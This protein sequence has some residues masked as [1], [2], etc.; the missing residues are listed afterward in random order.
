[1]S[2]GTAS[3]TSV[4]SGGSAVAQYS[5][6]LIGATIND[7]GYE[8]INGGTAS[9]T[10]IGIGGSI[11]LTN[12]GYS[13]TG[14]TISFNSTTDLLTVTSGTSIYTQTLAG[15]YTGDSFTSA[16]AGVGGTT[17]LAITLTGPPCYCAGTLILTDNGERPVEDLRAGDSV[18]TLSGAIRPIRWVGQ[19][20]LAISRHLSPEQVQ[21]VLIRTD[22]IA[23][24]KPHRDLRV[25]PDHAVLF[26]RGLIP[27]RLLINGASIQQE[28]QCQSVTYYHLE[29]DTHDILL[30]EGLPAESYLDTGNRSLFENGGVPMILHP[31]C[32]DGQQRR[33]SASCRPFVDRPADVEPV[34]R[35]LAM[36][37]IGLGLDLPAEPDT[38]TDP[39]LHVVLDGQA[40]NPISIA[41]GRYT[42]LLPLS[43]GP[44]RLV[45][46]VVRPSD[47]RPWIEDQRRLGVRLSAMTLRIGEKV[48][49][50]SLE[51]PALTNGWWNAEH[52]DGAIRRW[53]D[54]NAVLPRS[55]PAPGVLEITLADTLA[56]PLDRDAAADR[57]RC[58]A[59]A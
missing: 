40:I 57:T 31:N 9:F 19:R 37:A 14:E 43:D 46:R 59:A 15:N 16:N 17:E 56:Y 13:S 47:L 50:I 45:S 53:T 36:R 41:G 25:S 34:W 24:G 2:G 32:N 4:E 38:T 11:L 28:E 33:E 20:H 39:D 52:D 55:V 49:T 44:V 42:F 51:D 21:P 5:G 10:S 35:Q 8:I 22:A 26:D 18:V 1:M 12:F 58:P 6:Q 7:G 30:A 29:L 3:S 23:D 48:E 27:A 54:G